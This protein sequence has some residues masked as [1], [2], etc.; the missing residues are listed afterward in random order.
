M[1]PQGKIPH[2]LS[3]NL[4]MLC[5]SAAPSSQGF[6]RALI[7][8]SVVPVS[9][10]IPILPR[11]K[12][13]QRGVK[14]LF[15]SYTGRTCSIVSSTHFQVSIPCSTLAWNFNGHHQPVLSYVHIKADQSAAHGND[16]SQHG[17]NTL[18]KVGLCRSL[19]LV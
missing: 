1:W 6:Q 7:S 13:R 10:I 16:A 14:L 3:Y 18:N 9:I 19:S 11:W 5:P 2:G 15:L 12:L 4:I 8:I 17:P